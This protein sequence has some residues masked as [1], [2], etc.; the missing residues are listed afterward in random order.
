M[1]TKKVVEKKAETYVRQVQQA[2]PK[3]THLSAKI[4][5]DLKSG[6][7]NLS[8]N[9]NLRMK[10]DEVIQLAI[11]VMGFEVVRAEFTPQDVLI[12]DRMNSRYLRANYSDISYLKTSGL[13]FYALQS[14]FWNELFVP[15]AKESSN[16]SQR[17]TVQEQGKTVNLLLN[18]E[19]KLTYDF[20]IDTLDSRIKALKVTPKSQNAAHTFSWTYNQFVPFSQSTFPARMNCQAQIGKTKGEM[21]LTLDKMTEDSDWKVKS[22]IPSKFKQ[23]DI[24]TITK[25][26][27]KLL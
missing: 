18:D 16:I 4:K 12:L 6:S 14:L 3:A 21:T 27:Q 8:V 20:T 13:D 19:Q 24:Q 23:A 5:V 1:S 7:K 2:T 26:L 10:R 17:F 15:N 9:G 25:I 11:R 22:E